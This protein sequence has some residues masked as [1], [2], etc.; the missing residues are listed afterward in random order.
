MPLP[1]GN[2]L[3]EVPFLTLVDI[4]DGGTTGRPRD[5]GTPGRL[6][7][8][9]VLRQNDVPMKENAVPLPGEV[10]GAGPVGVPTRVVALQGAVNIR[11]L[12]GYPT[13]D[14]GR[15]RWGQV[16]RS[17]GLHRLTTED[18]ATLERLGLR[19]VYDFRTEAEQVKS[20]SLLPVGIRHEA[21]PIGGT[22]SRNQDL[23]DLLVAGRLGDVPPDFLTR[24][25]V[26]MAE[27]A[28]ST[29]G[30]FL[31]KLADQDGSPAL[32][33]C[34]AGKDRTGMSAALLLSALG[35]DEAT[36]LDDYELS[37]TH[38]TASQ[39]AK[40][41]VKLDAAGIDLAHYDAVFG[42]PRHAMAVTLDTLRAQHG[43]VIAYLEAE[44]GVTAEVV[45]A[46]RARLVEA[47]TPVLAPDRA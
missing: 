13:L 8:R 46:L 39:L 18:V 43:S 15:V 2:S 40:L 42:A 24:T 41:Q 28:A 17:A 26:T 37:A 10:N 7:A 6:R 5:D 11:D 30:S 16:Y 4:L 36:I 34:H 47:P 25:Y 44:A 33:H 45:T 29:F 35:V 12:G 32:F 9:R 27:T 19:V 21:L 1:T 14:G 31:T 23:A 20:P 22:A 38:F 3:P